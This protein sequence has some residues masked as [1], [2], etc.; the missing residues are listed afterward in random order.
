[1]PQRVT[2]QLRSTN[3]A[4]TRAFYEDGLGFRV[5]WEHRFEPGFP[6]FAEVSR[7]GLSLFLTEHAGDCQVGGAAYIV[8]DDLDALHREITQRGVR[9]DDP[10]GDTPWGTREMSVI[11]PD[12]N[13]LRFAAAKSATSGT[14]PGEAGASHSSG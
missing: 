1:M 11:D 7:D 10:P 9:V 4:R 12:G 5:Q 13:R 2:P 14:P 3:W 6:V 8:V